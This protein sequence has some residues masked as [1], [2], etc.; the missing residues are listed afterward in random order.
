MAKNTQTQTPVLDFM[1]WRKIAL[2]VSGV[3]LLLSIISL[4]VNGLKFGLDFTG[5]L[6]VEVNYSEPANLSLIREQLADNDIENAVVCV[7]KVVL[8]CCSLLLW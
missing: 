8:A 1:K 2:I 7:T 3:L 4:A 6:Q 5:G